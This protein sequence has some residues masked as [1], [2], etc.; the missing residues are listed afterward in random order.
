[1]APSQSTKP[2]K[3]DPSLYDSCTA[4]VT[5]HCSAIISDGS[6]YQS[7]ATIAVLPFWSS[8]VKDAHPLLLQYLFGLDYTKLFQMW[9]VECI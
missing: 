6:C 3:F 5:H 1:M 2:F 7:K 9:Q 8:F 4:K